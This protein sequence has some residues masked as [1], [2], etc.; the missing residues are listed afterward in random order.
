[1]TY[2]ATTVHRFTRENGSLAQKLVREFDLIDTELDTMNTEIDT[3][4]PTVPPATMKK[5]TN[6]YYDPATGELKFTAEA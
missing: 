3:L 6:L 5:V 1:M 2:T 4:V